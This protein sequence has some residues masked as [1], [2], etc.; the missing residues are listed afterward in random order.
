MLCL[1]YYSFL[2]FRG[3]SM[4]DH[5]SGIRI[6]YVPITCSI[7]LECRTVDVPMNRSKFLS[8]VQFLSNILYALQKRS[9][10]DVVRPCHTHTRS[11]S[12]S[13]SKKQSTRRSCEHVSHYLRR[14][15]DAGLTLFQKKML[16][17]RNGSTP[18]GF[19][20]LISGWV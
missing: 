3:L 13:T 12:Y 7:P 6:Q 4:E 1:H 11:A 10:G 19:H 20:L 16:Y 17:L 5:N 8:K 15:F 14:T 18:V 9:D 2:S